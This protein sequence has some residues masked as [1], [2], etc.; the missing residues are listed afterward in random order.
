MNCGLPILKNARCMFLSRL[1]ILGSLMALLSQ[2]SLARAGQPSDKMRSELEGY[3]ENVTAANASVYNAK[4]SN[5][6]G[7]DCAKIIQDP[8]GGYIAVYHVEQSSGLFS[9]YLA[10]STDLIHW[11]YQVSLGTGASQPT[12][13]LLSNGGFLVLWEQVNSSGA[14]N[15]IRFNYYSSR[16]NLMVGT[17]TQ[18]YD[19]AQSL[20]TCAEG[21]PNI[22]SVN[23]VPDLANSVIDVGGHYN[24]NCS[25]DQQQRGSLVNFS[26]WVST[27]QPQINNAVKYWGVAGNIGERD[28]LDYRGY[29]FELIEGDSVAGNWAD[30]DLYC[31]DFQT[32]NADKLSITTAGGSTSFANPR[33]TRLIAPNGEPAIVTTIFIPSQGAASGEA[34]ELI[35]YRTYGFSTSGGDQPASLT[36]SYSTTGI[37]AN[38]SAFSATGGLDGAGHAY[39][40]YL[41]PQSMPTF[42]EL[43]FVNTPEYSVA[44]PGSV[45]SVTAS[46][47]TIALPANEYGTLNLLA[48]G[49][50]NNQ[51]SQT[52]QI[53]YSDS[54]TTSF[55]QSMSS[56]FSPQ[57]YSGE[58]T[59]I[60]M[61][62]GN[63]YNGTE[64]T[65]DIYSVYTYSF[66]LDPSKTLSS[67]TLPNN[68]NVQVL[69]I[70]PVPVAPQ[71]VLMNHTY[72]LTG[73]YNDGVTFSSSGGMDGAGNAYSGILLGIDQTW[74]NN[75]FML[76]VPNGYNVVKCAAQI[77]PLSS[78]QFST[79]KM[80]ATGVNGVQTSQTFTVTYTDNSTSTF[81]QSLSDWHTFSGY[82][83][84]SEA[85][86][87]AYRDTSAG[88]TQSIATN[89][90][91]YAFSLNN[92]KIVKSVTVP[93][94][95]NVVVVGMTLVP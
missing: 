32:G 54:S 79:L 20:S 33:I 60:E 45:D 78:G 17:V 68:N 66:G 34:G 24:M 53:T 39:S 73:I 70:T 95:G 42:P 44:A 52:F 82:S 89:L 67:I 88:G 55:T 81:T 9:V 75:T 10:T 48:T 16:A 93:N 74:T 64:D 4:D 2:C 87:M 76:A 26:K 14:D 47:Q 28:A 38:G 80:L 58:V 30:W 6:N 11:T 63:L 90:Y 65:S 13:Q 25:V 23:L 19:A 69:A 61:S 43:N 46:G 31:Y 50:N 49:V 62:Y 40:S 5:G 56:W 27:P 77:I 57:K 92:A 41:F 59:S 72:N 3:I 15:H 91:G 94:N 18:T 35:Y 29:N 21:T 85:Y 36:S 1:W 84:E 51:T 37:Y 22:Y 83:G 86:T 7:M 71:W 8:N 12:I